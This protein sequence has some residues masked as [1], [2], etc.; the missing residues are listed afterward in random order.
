MKLGDIILVK[1]NFDPVA[2]IIRIVTGSQWNHVAWA[3][4]SDYLLES[5]GKGIIIR[6]LSKY[7][8]KWLYKTK[9]LTL[10][11][12]DPK[13]LKE[14][15]S[16]ALAQRGQDK[17]AYM[18]LIYTMIAISLGFKGNRLTCSGFIAKALST[19][20]WHFLINKNPY[21]ITPED[22]AKSKKIIPNRVQ[23]FN[24]LQFM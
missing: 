3:L 9:I 12:I 19:V 14:A 13:D 23:N 7:R 4:G 10:R 2:L 18:K 15:L 6:P 16:Y 22:I 8:S 20:G 24:V 5:T 21:E 1:Y 17:W 11:E